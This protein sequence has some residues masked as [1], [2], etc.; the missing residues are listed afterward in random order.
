MIKID[1]ETYFK[2]LKPEAFDLENGVSGY[3]LWE[4]TALP[5]RTFVHSKGFGKGY[6]GYSWAT[7][8]AGFDTVTQE[9]K[10]HCHS[11]E[12]MT[13]LYFKE[14]SINKIE[15]KDDLE[16]A[17]YTIDFIRKLANSGVIEIDTEVTE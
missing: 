12:D 9:L 5:N 10:V 2:V 15:D 4:N 7:V 11:N 13:W 17:R 8:W 6:Y 3:A 1:K 16:C 14:D